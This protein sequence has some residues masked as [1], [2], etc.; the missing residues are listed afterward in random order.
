MEAVMSQYS[1]AISQMP[2]TREQALVIYDPD[3]LREIARIPY[4]TAA[5]LLLRA[6]GLP[7]K[8][9]RETAS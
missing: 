1:F 6:L 7:I 9:A 3:T 4:D 8:P 2:E 5:V